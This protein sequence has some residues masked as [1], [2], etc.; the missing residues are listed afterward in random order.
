MHW[1]NG[2]NY[3]GE[4]PWILQQV[5]MVPIRHAKNQSSYCVTPPYYSIGTTNQA[6][7]MTLKNGKKQ[8]K[9][10]SKNIGHKFHKGDEVL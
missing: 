7:E 5:C 4:F 2:N 8:S 9:K 1:I 6:K 3:Y 10:K